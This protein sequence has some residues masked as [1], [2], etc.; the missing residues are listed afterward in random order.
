MYIGV[1][2]RGE[3]YGALPFSSEMSVQH[4]VRSNYCESPFRSQL[5]WPLHRFYVNR[6]MN[7]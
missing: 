2:E 6:S 3:W 4:I 1:V 5:P 7:L